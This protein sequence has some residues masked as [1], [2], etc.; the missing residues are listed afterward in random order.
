M[1][2][3]Q[4]V[5]VTG[6]HGYIGS[7]MAPALAHRRYDVVGLVGSQHAHAPRE[8]DAGVGPGPADSAVQGVES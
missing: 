6:H 2:S 8:R 3:I 5:L 7:V 4:R 1:S